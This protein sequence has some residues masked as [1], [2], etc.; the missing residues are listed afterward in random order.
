MVAIS[1]KSDSKSTSPLNLS[2]P[3]EA[4][5]TKGTLSFSE[6]LHG[7]KG[8]DTKTLQNGALVLAL[9]DKDLEVSSAKT[10]KEDT[11]L[12][13]LKND[14][15][16]LNPAAT[17]NLTS[18]ELKALIKDAKEYLKHQITQTDGYKKAQIDELPKTLKGLVQ[19]AKKFDI[20]VSKITVE[21]VNEHKSLKSI[22]SEL[23]DTDKHTKSE[24]KSDAK[25]TDIDTPNLKLNTKKEAAQ[26]KNQSQNADIDFNEQSQKV[27]N[28]VKTASVSTVKETPLFK[29]QTQQAVTTEQTLQAR[30]FKTPEPKT[31]KERADETLKLL[32]RG[33]KG[34]KSDGISKL[35]SDFSVATARVIAPSAT[36][37]AQK[38]LESLL[39]GDSSEQNTSKVD[40]FN[41]PKADSFE[42][43]LNEAKQMTKYLSQDVK[44]AI[45]NYKAPFTRIKVQLNP[46]RLGEVD[47]TVVQRGKNLHVNITSNNAAINALAMNANDLR[48]QLNNNGIQNAS[49]NFN[50][51]SDSGQANQ[52]QNHSQNQQASQEY[53][54]F[55]KEEQN[56][57][58]LSSL[59]IVVPNYA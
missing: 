3:S 12:A 1:T 40:G 38:S 9:D 59:E 56:E 51:G 25:A 18:E 28:E 10:S 27:K 46:Q 23:L 55:D 52:Q 15:L 49:L 14:P 48:A 11:L 16:D 32:L 19:L 22:E 44:Q 36:T 39:R 4:N 26:Q 37:E 47:L 6:L 35:T 57:E 21:K 30:E 50:S 8:K 53:N 43:K 54:Y 24:K 5:E 58:V 13:L 7:A 33:E 31:A 41:A 34:Q 29:A 17:K 20:D 45:E 42:V 2:T